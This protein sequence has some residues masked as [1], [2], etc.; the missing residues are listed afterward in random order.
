MLFL[1]SPVSLLHRERLTW[2]DGNV[3]NE[4]LSLETDFTLSIWMAEL[5]NSVIQPPTGRNCKDINIKM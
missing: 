4:L 5:K 2:K 3:A 1:P